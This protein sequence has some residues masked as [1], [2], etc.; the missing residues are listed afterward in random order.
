MAYVV[1]KKI[2]GHEYYYLKESKRV[3]GKVKTKNIAYFGKKK[4]TKKDIEEVLKKV[5]PK[6][7]SDKKD[8]VPKKKQD[9]LYK[10]LPKTKTMVDIQEM[11]TFCKKKG[12]VFS[13]SEIYGGLAGFWDYG[14][15]GVELKNNIKQD[16][17]KRFVQSRQDVVGLDGAII[18]H[19]KVWKASG[20]VDNFKDVYVKCKNCKKPNKIDK[21][22]IG[23][24]KCPECEGEFEVIGDVNL[25]FSTEVGPVE[26]VNSYLRPET[27]QLIFTDFRLVHDTSRVQLPF[28]IAQ[29]GKAFRNEISPRDFLFRSREFEQMEIEFFIHP[30]KK[31]C[32]L[33]K[34]KDKKFEFQLLSEDDQ[35]KDIEHKK[36]TL[37][38]MLK[39]K[40]LGE[41]HAYWLK[42]NYQWFLDLGI[43]KKDLRLREHMKDE[44]AHYSSACFDIEYRYSFGWKEVHGNANRGQ[45]DLK[46]HKKASSK[47]M[48]I[49]DQETEKKVIPRV[50][51]PSQ[52]LDRAFL[53]VL[54]NAYYDDKERGNVVLKLEPKLAPVKIGIFPLVNKLN[55]EAEEIYDSLKEE[56][57][58][59]FDTSGSVGRRY[60][61]ADEIGV[62]YCVTFD[63]DSLKDKAVT[64]RNRDTT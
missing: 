18:T 25:M 51:E 14:P 42:E 56:F 27:A 48:E 40:M 62:P 28:G 32:Y 58:C 45:Y 4:P 11:A 22:E 41:W 20:H 64:I 2:S 59:Q 13:N 49:F 60:A 21:N 39:K 63:F 53:T 26:G 44:L 30:E 8:V 38:E 47:K 10:G 37:G 17:W 24:V 50:I 9:K 23:K 7:N 15:L 1:K 5:I 43:D 3:N 12:I 55:K 34:E 54:F 52:G 6:K 16:W 29:I 31:E 36:I 19:P 61:R 35:K 46:Q 57:V 33:L